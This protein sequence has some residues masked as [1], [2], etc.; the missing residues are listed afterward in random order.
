MKIYTEL[1][2]FLFILFK[3]HIFGGA[4]ESRD[5]HYVRKAQSIGKKGTIT[6]PPF[7]ARD[8]G[9]T[10]SRTRGVQIRSGW[11]GWPPNNW[12][13]NRCK[14]LPNLSCW[15]SKDIRSAFFSGHERSFGLDV[16]IPLR[17]FQPLSPQKMPLGA[18]FLAQNLESE[19]WRFHWPRRAPRIDETLYVLRNLKTFR[20][21]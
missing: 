1:G 20:S 13:W 11:P 10:T 7:P 21:I 6:I 18:W 12:R 5:L 19:D 2:W 15:T 16:R 17:R 14:V 4:T 8:R 3:F 9:S